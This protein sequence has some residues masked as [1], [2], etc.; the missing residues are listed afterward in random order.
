MWISDHPLST[1]GVGTQARWLIDG[2]LRTERYSFRCFGG[3]LK[4]D[5]MNTITVTPDW[6]IKPT[7]GYGDIN[8]LRQVL[9]QE[10]PDALVL[11]TDP[12]FF[13]WT[14][15]MEDEIHQVCPIAY[16]HLWDNLP[17]PAFNRVLYESTDLLNCINYP[18]YE[19]VHD[20]LPDRTNYVPHAAPR[21]LYFPLQQEAIQNV[22]KTFFGNSRADHFIVLFVGRN[23]RRKCTSDII[24]AFKM[25]VDELFERHGHR[26]AT[27]VM[28]TDPHD[29]EGPNL[30]HMLD[31]FNVKE[32]V[33]FSNDRVKFEEMNLLYNS[34]DALVQFS[35]AEGFGL[36]VLE[37]KM[38][39]KPIIAMKTGGVTRQVEDHE[40]NEQ[41]GVAIDPEVQTLAGNQLVPFIYEDYASHRTLA[42]AYMKVF[43]MGHDERSRIGL[44]AREHALKNYNIDEMISTWDRTLTDLI[45]RWK[46]GECPNN[47]R[48]RTVTL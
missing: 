29:R 20:W 5:D 40:T 11:F 32:N 4:H 9:V 22:R 16:N 17:V 23:A 19:F 30:Y 37:A 33:V 3:A 48:W 14:W 7:N 27:L 39:G 13:T 25:F 28:H 31:A 41:F 6:I 47:K 10:K 38:A 36:P 35:S 42:N 12:R 44:R 15:E 18:T 46:R 8:M 1:S 43:E 34:C 45:D 2:L 26:K 24:A 21:E